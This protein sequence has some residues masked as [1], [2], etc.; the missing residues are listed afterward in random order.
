MSQ[1]FALISRETLT[2]V[3]GA[4]RKDGEISD[5]WWARAAKAWRSVGGHT[6]GIVSEPGHRGR[7]WRQLTRR[8]G[9]PWLPPEAWAAA[10]SAHEGSWWTAWHHWLC[11]HGGGGLVP[12]RKLG[13]RTGLAAAPGRYVHQRYDD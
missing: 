2:T 12:A 5:R 3:P 9:D 6:A 13:P 1:Q 11:Q 8:R 4:I 10:A 7:R